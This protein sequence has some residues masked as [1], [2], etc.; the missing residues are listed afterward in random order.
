MKGQGIV[1]GVG[2]LSLLLQSP[3]NGSMDAR[4]Y[5][6]RICSSPMLGSLLSKSELTQDLLGIDT[7]ISLRRLCC[8]ASQFMLT[9][10]RGCS[11][12]WLQNSEQLVKGGGSVE[13]SQ[14]IQE[15]RSLLCLLYT[16]WLSLFKALCYFQ[17][18][19]CFILLLNM[20]SLSFLLCHRTC[21]I[22][23]TPRV[24]IQ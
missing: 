11:Q 13:D 1:L 18:I 8:S 14:G 19:L 16:L 6:E 15:V 10:E 3:G 12:Q 9:E 4:T 17:L 23:Q 2:A 21:L 7:C 5:T 24:G 20:F 22:E